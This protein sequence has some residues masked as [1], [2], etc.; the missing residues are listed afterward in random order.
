MKS[1]RRSFDSSSTIG[2]VLA[3]RSAREGCVSRYR[4]IC[5]GRLAERVSGNPF[6]PCGRSDL[7]RDGSFCGISRPNQMVELQGVP[8][9]HYLEL[10]RIPLD[11]DHGATASRP[12]GGISA[13]VHHSR[14]YSRDTGPAIDHALFVGG[15]FAAACRR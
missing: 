9:I 4:S 1:S 8:G 7:C 12:G 13:L 10:H 6:I 3:S 5:G 15:R 11:G 2:V 14:F